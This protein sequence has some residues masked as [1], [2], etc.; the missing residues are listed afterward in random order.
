MDSAA[1]LISVR[2]ARLRYVHDDAAGYTRVRVGKAFRYFNLKGEPCGADDVARINALAIPPAWTQVWICPNPKGHIQAT[3]RDLRGRKQYRY[4]ARWREVRDTTKYD[5]LAAFAEVLPRIRA[6]VH[7]ALGRPLS[8]L[9]LLASVVHLLERTHIRIGNDEYAK[10]NGS[11]GLTT[12][13][14]RHVQVDGSVVHFRFRGK[15][16]VKRSI[17]LNDRRLAR[18]IRK[19]QELPGYEL[20]HYADADGRVRRICSGDVNE[21]LR[22]VAGSSLSAKEFRTWAGTV[23]AARTLAQMTHETAEQAKRNIV[24][25]VKEVSSHLGNTPAV[26]RKCYI[27]P[28]IFE[29]YLR[30][31]LHAAMN[32][33]RLLAKSPTAL[34]SE[35]L[36]VRDLIV[37]ASASA[38]RRKA[39]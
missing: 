17:D 26:C 25:A 38:P 36:A 24:A 35:E 3:G 33:P 20:F 32:K 9:T 18:I 28:V 1:S 31:D 34:N 4:H 22:E 23:L 37:E 21:F 8:R 2:E 29:A 12:L 14:D 13:R 7:G 39:A 16:G 15:S 5:K 6:A 11:Y 30:K 10:E 27:H 19:C